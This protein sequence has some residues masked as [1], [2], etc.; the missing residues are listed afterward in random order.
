MDGGTDW[1]AAL[2]LQ[3]E[4]GADEALAE[5]PLDRL[6]TERPLAAPDR[7]VTTA[8]RDAPGLGTVAGAV[9]AAGEGNA[10]GTFP[11]TG[12]AAGRVSAAASVSAVTGLGGVDGSVR[13]AFPG[14]PGLPGAAPSRTP[15]E[16]ALAVA[17]Q[18][19]T[20]DALRA[21]IVGFDGC[22]LRDTATQAVLPDGDPAARVLLV[23]EPPNAD[24][25]R[26]GRPFAAREGALLDRMLASIDLKRE[27]LLLAPLVPWRPPGG[28]P[29]SPAE[30]AICLPFLQRLIVL[31]AP[32]RLVI[33]GSLAARTLLGPQAGRRRQP[34]WTAYAMPQPVQPVPSLVLPAL[35]MLL[36]T[37]ALRR[38][39]WAGL[40]LLRHAIDSAIT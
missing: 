32:A 13:P 34:G 20:L 31:A 1:L 10:A 27:S 5:D 40:R 12:P 24:E 22:R 30:L 4:W 15:A 23:G 36:K 19:D 38:D 35:G 25:D 18:A 7:S 26:S 39:A 16:A 37:P 14:G 11:V 28:R 2:R 33:L 8:R 9:G 3:L 29:P 17:S 6:G 21:A